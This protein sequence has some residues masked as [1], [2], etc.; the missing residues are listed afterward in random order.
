LIQIIFLELVHE[1]RPFCGQLHYFSGFVH[2]LAAF[3][4]QV[5]YFSGFVHGLAAFCGRQTVNRDI[6]VLDVCREDAI[7]GVLYSGCYR[8][9]PERDWDFDTA[10]SYGT[11]DNPH[12]NEELLGKGTNEKRVSWIHR[13][14]TTTYPCYLPVLGDSAGAGRVWL[15]RCKGM[16][17]FC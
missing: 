13:T 2:G 4:G 1:K 15:T 16:S 11:S 9:S 3:C 10:E 12:D 14:A 8:T 7:Q 6:E 5:H 17:N